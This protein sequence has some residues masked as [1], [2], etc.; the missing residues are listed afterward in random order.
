MWRER[1]LF[2]LWE[3]H[4][5]RVI[6]HNDKDDVVGV[7]SH[8]SNPTYSNTFSIGG[9]IAV[10][11]GT[12]VIDRQNPMLLHH[13]TDAQN[14]KVLD[15][16]SDAKMR[17]DPVQ[18]LKNL[19]LAIHPFRNAIIVT[20]DEYSAKMIEKYQ[21]LKSCYGCDIRTRLTV[22][23]GL[24]STE[25]S[26]FFNSN[27]KFKLEDEVVEFLCDKNRA[28]GIRAFCQEQAL[29]RVP[30]N[31]DPC[32]LHLSLGLGPEVRRN[33]SRFNDM[34]DLLNSMFPQHVEVK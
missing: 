1:S 10:K 32:D 11:K 28:D 19:N 21:Q 25:V 3:D 7:T 18:L 29:P 22:D 20:H 4:M 34:I 13:H 8:P 24:S 30:R 31:G 17:H 26:A 16:Y 33:R 15:V 9:V 2:N 12:E 5:I 23:G 27:S 14:Q 6:T